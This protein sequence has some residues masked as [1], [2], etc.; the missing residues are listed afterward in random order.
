M[1][2]EGFDFALLEERQAAALRRI[3]ELGGRRI[4]LLRQAEELLE[5]LRDA[6]VEAARLKAPRRRMQD[7]AH[8]GGPTFY[9]W[10]EGA[11]VEIRPKKAAKKR[12]RGQSP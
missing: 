8:V 4:E 7:L 6:V 3:A 9:G 12:D 5:P 11:G 1:A 2:D 10:L